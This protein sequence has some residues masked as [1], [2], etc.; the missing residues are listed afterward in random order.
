MFA[1]ITARHQLRLPLLQLRDAD[2]NRLRRPHRGHRPGPL[3][4]D[5]RAT[6]RADLHGHRRRADRHQPPPPRAAAAGPVS[7]ERPGQAG[8]A[9]PTPRRSPRSTRRGSTSG[10][11]RSRPHPLLPTRC[12]SG[13]ASGVLHLVAERAPRVIGFAKVG[14]YADPAPYYAARRRGH[15]LRRRRRRRQGAGRRP[16]EALA[17]AA[18]RRGDVQARRKGLLDER[19]RAS[20]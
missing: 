13:S 8:R 11:R 7:P 15:R 2:D 6:D 10:S 19:G 20:T 16:V 3:V 5:H 4:R 18:E 14:P 9:R 12:E 17:T 1:Q